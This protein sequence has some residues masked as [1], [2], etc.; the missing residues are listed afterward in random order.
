MKLKI[1]ATVFFIPFLLFAQEKNDGQS[2]ELP[3]FVI[4]GVQ[5]INI[6]TAAKNSPKLVST[7]SKEFITPQFSPEMF[8]LSGVSNPLAPNLELLENTESI[9]GQLKAGAGLYTLPKGELNLGKSFKH[10]SIFG[11]VFGLNE[12]EYIDNAGYNIS[13]GSVNTDFFVSNKS[14]FLPGLNVFMNIQYLRDS[15]N[16]FGSD[17]LDFGRKSQ[18]TNL[19]FGI[20]N[21]FNKNLKYGISLTGNIY[22]IS[23]NDY[24]ESKFTL[25]AFIDLAVSNIGIHSEG[26]FIS[27]D[28]TNALT[29]KSNYNYFST[30]SRAIL[31][32]NNAVELKAGINLSIYDGNSF[33]APV[34]SISMKLSDAITFLGEYSPGTNFHST[35]DFKNVN[36]YAVFDSTNNIIEKEKHKFKVA[37]RYQF[38]KYI[39][40]ALGAS[41]SQFDN[42]IYFSDIKS[43]GLFNVMH[44]DDVSMLGIFGNFMFHLGPFGYFYGDIEWQ[45][46]EDSENNILPYNPNLISNLIYG[47]SFDNGLSLKSKITY[48]SSAYSDLKNSGE[49]PSYMD[50]ALFFEYGLSENLRLTLELNNL[51]NRKNY[52]WSGYQEK[53]LDFVL[54]VDYRW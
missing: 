5:T 11:T 31:K 49:I 51:I 13:G 38:L 17:S 27:Q 22:E 53:G 44:K 8:A 32:I 6:P 34:G 33:F 28:L 52:L 40:I 41:Y 20:K 39:E 50:L 45:Y 16:F 12:R 36:R 43:A 14:K 48:R 37:I 10:A 21:T 24:G 47:Y 15:Y 30:D 2:I 54:G 35:S 25:N 42:F 9:S 1:I 3:D 29:S 46:V 18:S 4:T 19:S 26:I 7:L 23:E